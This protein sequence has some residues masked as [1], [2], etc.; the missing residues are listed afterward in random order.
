MCLL[1]VSSHTTGVLAC[2]HGIVVQ[3]SFA[4]FLLG[5]PPS[6]GA[7]E[8]GTHFYKQGFSNNRITRKFE[9]AL[10]KAHSVLRALGIDLN[11]MVWILL[12]VLPQNRNTFKKVF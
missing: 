11:R 3:L 9:G 1:K 12:Q 2:C 10:N 4:T 6:S 7:I 5:R 8:S